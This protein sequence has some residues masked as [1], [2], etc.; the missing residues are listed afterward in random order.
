MSRR[1]ALERIAHEI[2]DRQRFLATCHIRPDGD[3]IGSLLA[4]R[5]ALTGLG[6]EVLTVTASPI[7][8]QYAFLPGV[9]TI[10]QDLPSPEAAA[11]YDAGV[12]LDCDGLARTST[13]GPLLEATGFVV[14]IDH[15]EGIHAFGDARCVDPQ[16]PCTGDILLELLVDVMGVPLDAE[17]ATCLLACHIYDTG[18]F[19]QANATPAAFR[20]AARLV[21][22]GADPE[23][24]ARALFETRRLERARLRGRA[25][26]R[27]R[28]D[29]EYGIAWTTV[30][31]SDLA[32]GGAIGADTEGI[33]DEVRA[34]SGARL[35]CLVVELRDGTSKVSLR[36]RDRSLNLAEFAAR[37][38]GGGHERAAGCEIPG[39]AEAVSERVLA[40]ARE[41]LGPCRPDG[42]G[43]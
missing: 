17:L 33:I 32:D 8:A 1:D 43:A 9:E 6:K 41:A 24:I 38:G 10:T 4:F 23:S 11:T 29:T 7:P 30:L 36:S 42:G 22:S 35:A 37:F 15:P 26:A 21:E 20:N 19:A 34:I 12:A 18:R 25:M 27:A 28:L 3:A 16:A 40:S 2:G 31:Q 39:G 13:V 5:H 14:D